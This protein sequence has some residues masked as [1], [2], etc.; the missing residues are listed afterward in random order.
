MIG[1]HCHTS[2][3]I[4]EEK[5][6]PLFY[7]FRI[8][9][10][11]FITCFVFIHSDYTNFPKNDKSSLILKS[12]GKTVTTVLLLLSILLVLII[13]GLIYT[14]QSRYSKRKNNNRHHTD[15]LNNECVYSKLLIKNEIDLN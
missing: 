6:Y 9:F 11:N 15:R 14:L 5:I 12:S 7:F 10:S 3:H 13:I 4:T 2:I 1:R 8:T